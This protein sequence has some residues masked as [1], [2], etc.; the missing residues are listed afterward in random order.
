MVNPEFLLLAIVAHIFFSYFLC[1]VDIS[2]KYGVISVSL[3][4]VLLFGGVSVWLNVCVCVCMCERIIV[5]C[6]SLCVCGV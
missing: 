4:T 5:S 1:L 3:T 6:E 2:G